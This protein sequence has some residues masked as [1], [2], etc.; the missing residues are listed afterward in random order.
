M[1]FTRSFAG[2]TGGHLKFLD[3]MKHT[4]LSGLAEPVLYQTPESRRVPGNIFNDHPWRR[5]DR[6]RPF[7][8]YFV[9]G[10]D[11]FTLDHAGIDPGGSPVINLI[12][13]VRH[14][15][16]AS[17]LFACLARPAV[18]ICVSAAVA[19]AIRDHANG[20]VHTI[21]AGVAVP[22]SPGPSP[23]TR[24][25]DG[26][27]RV[28]IGGLKNPGAARDIATR[29]SGFAEIDLVT[30]HLPRSLFLRQIAEATICIFLPLPAEGFFL[31]PLEAMALGRGVVVPDC[32]GNRDYCRSDENCVMPAYDPEALTDAA[33]LLVRDHPRLRRLSSAGLATASVL[34]IERERSLYHDILARLARRSRLAR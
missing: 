13:G 6:P 23:G 17:E 4:E 3:Y 5:I 11:W 33:L 7:P 21:T 30:G 2:F 27:P 26:P 1:L 32:R 14:G 24:P 12:Q 16:P 25:L 34:T 31:P 29:L 28:F 8:A 10:G 20:E 9:A 19:E 22:P 15:D 18:R